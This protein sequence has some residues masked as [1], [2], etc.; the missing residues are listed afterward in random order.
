MYQAWVLCHAYSCCD[1]MTTKSSH[2]VI[3]QYSQ[4]P[5]SGGGVFQFIEYLG[6]VGPYTLMH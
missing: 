5:T 3:H 1:S 2:L 6:Y 4:L